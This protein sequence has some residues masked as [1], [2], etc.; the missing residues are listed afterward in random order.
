MHLLNITEPFSVKFRLREFLYEKH[1]VNPSA[2][3]GPK[4]HVALLCLPTFLLSLHIFCKFPN[5]SLLK[6]SLFRKMC[7]DSCSS[8]KAELRFSWS[9]KWGFKIFLCKMALKFKHKI[10]V[11]LGINAS[12]FTKTPIQHAISAISSISIIGWE[13]KEINLM[14]KGCQ[15]RYIIPPYLTHVILHHNA[16]FFNAILMNFFMTCRAESKKH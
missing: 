3:N 10:K 4:L 1:F 2:S 6:F 11:K 9:I 16:H 14:G 5:N 12:L 13:K 15:R 8:W 7:K